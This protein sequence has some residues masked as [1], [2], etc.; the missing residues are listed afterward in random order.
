L[1][2]SVA[3]VGATPLNPSTTVSAVAPILPHDDCLDFGVD[4]QPHH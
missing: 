4:C 3:P 1:I 2:P